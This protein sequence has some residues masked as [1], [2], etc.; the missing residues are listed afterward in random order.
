MK[1]KGQLTFAWILI[2]FG[3]LLLIGNFIGIDFGDIFW[4]LVFIVAGLLLIF[5]PQVISPA[6]ARFYFA[7]DINVNSK[8]DMN[9]NDLR[10]F[11]G[12]VRIDLADLNLTSDETKFIIS[13]FAGE[14]DIFAPQDVGVSI[15]TMAFVTDS[16]IDGKKMEYI[17]SGMDYATEGYEN[18]SKKFK[19]IMQCFAADVKLKTV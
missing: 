5:R 11:A 3:A 1:T 10:M 17:F 4:P 13:A 2:G 19:L 6:G 7:G 15:S 18:A 12:D 8:W 16:R 14:V 9:K